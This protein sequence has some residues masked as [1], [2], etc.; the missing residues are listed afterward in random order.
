MPYY[1]VSGFRNKSKQYHNIVIIFIIKD[2]DTTHKSPM[3]QKFNK[4]LQC[5]VNILYTVYKDVKKTLNSI[6][7]PNISSGRL[8][9]WY[10]FCDIVE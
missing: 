8:V 4:T 3:K 1:T 7:I 2:S 6:A 5:F 9:L 10:N